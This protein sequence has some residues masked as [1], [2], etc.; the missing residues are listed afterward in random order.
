MKIFIILIRQNL[1][2]GMKD[3][4]R[5]SQKKTYIILKYLKNRDFI[6]SIKCINSNRSIILNIIILYRE[7]YLKKLFFFN[8]LDGNIVI[9][10][11]NSKYHNNKLSFY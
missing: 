8:N 7:N 6:L 9:V 11:S 4:K 5:L 1:E 2:L 3:Y 10:F